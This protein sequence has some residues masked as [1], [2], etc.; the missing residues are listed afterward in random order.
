MSRA[1]RDAAHALEPR[2]RVLHDDD[3]E[4]LVLSLLTKSFINHA[5]RRRLAV[6]LSA[7]IRRVV[8]AH[9]KALY[10]DSAATLD[11]LREAVTTVEDLMRT[12]RRVLGAAHPLTVDIEGDLQKARAALRARET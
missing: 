8:L 12:A 7:P 10:L 2:E 11:D 6:V 1:I 9:A 4:D 3:R 5:G